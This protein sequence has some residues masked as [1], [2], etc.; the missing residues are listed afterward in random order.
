MRLF[1]WLLLSAFAFPA[2][3]AQQ[4]FPGTYRLIAFAAPGTHEPVGLDSLQKTNE[5]AGMRLILREDGSA[6]LY[7]GTDTTEAEYVRNAPDRT[8][9]L[10]DGTSNAIQLRF[11]HDT[12]VMRAMGGGP[13]FYFKRVREAAKK[14]ATARP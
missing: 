8:A 11:T 2:C 12:L 4:P 10:L 1:I 6:T 5:I 14:G 9:R 13:A 7:N 3:A